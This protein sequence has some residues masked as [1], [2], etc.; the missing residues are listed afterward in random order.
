[1][2]FPYFLKFKLE[3]WKNT[4]SE[5]QSVPSVVFTDSVELLHLWLQRTQQIWLWLDHL[6]MYM[7]RVFSWVVEK[8][9]LVWPV[10]SLDKT[11]LVFALLHFVLQGQTRLL[12]WYF[13]TSYLCI[14]TPFDE[15]DMFFFFV[16]VCVCVCLCVCLCVCISSRRSCRSS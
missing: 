14:S 10:C 2:I 12:F 1:M 5:P 16:C 15:K 9:C 6:V 13:W 4:W 8:W 7:C 3:F 11:S